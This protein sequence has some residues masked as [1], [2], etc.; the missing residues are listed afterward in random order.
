MFEREK[1]ASVP[2]QSELY[3]WA[4]YVEMRCLTDAD[5]HFGA[6]RLGDLMNFAG[7]LAALSDDAVDADESDV[8]DALL[9][10]HATDELEDQIAYEGDQ[11]VEPD[12]VPEADTR[13]G[14][15]AELTDDR[16]LWCESVFNLLRDREATLGDIYPFSIDGLNVSRLERTVPRDAYVFY[17]CCSLLRYVP[18]PVMQSLTSW[19]E[20]M[21]LEVLRRILPPNAEV[22]AYGTAR[23]KADSR[24]AGS[25]YERLTALAAELRGKVLAEEHDFHPRDAGDNGLDVVGWVPMMDSAKGVP[26]FFGQCACGVKWDA[27]QYE[28]GHERWR[29]FIHLSSPSSKLTFIPHHYRSMGQHWYVATDVSGILVDRL[30][31]LRFLAGD[32]SSVPTDVVSEAWSFQLAVV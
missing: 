14:R 12:E 22:D 10:G 28:A 21:S 1:L 26:S 30:R 25:Q 3:Y 6:V 8:L 31:A 32:F 2:A 7:D 9:E 29:E 24:F 17:L 16:R 19:F 18:K 27:K 20:F 13:L 4:D 15:A 5:G 23:G 11:D